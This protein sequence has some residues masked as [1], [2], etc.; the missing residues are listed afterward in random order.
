MFP[1][2]LTDIIKPKK[3]KKYQRRKSQAL[4][5]IS[6]IDKEYKEKVYK[7]WIQRRN[8]LDLGRPRL[9]SKNRKEKASMLEVQAPPM[10]IIN[11]TDEAYTDFESSRTSICLDGEHNAILFGRP[12][13][14]GAT[15]K[16]LG[17]QNVR[18]NLVPSESQKSINGLS[19]RQV[20]AFREVFDLFDGNGGGTIDADELDETLR[21]VNICLESHQ[22]AEV[23]LS[24]DHDGNGEIDFEEFMHLMTNTERFIDSLANDLM[25]DDE[26]AESKRKENEQKENMLFEALTEFMKKSAL[27]GM[28][29]I[30]DYYSSK[31]KR[32]QVPHVVNHYAAGAR[33]IGLS[34]KQ[35]KKHLMELKGSYAKHGGLNSPYARPLNTVP[36]ASSFQIVNIGNEQHYSRTHYSKEKKK[37]KEKRKQKAEKAEKSVKRR[38]TVRLFVKLPE[39]L[40]TIKHDLDLGY[41]EEDKDDSSLPMLNQRGNGWIGQRTEHIEAK[42]STSRFKNLTAVKNELTAEHLPMIR[43]NVTHA[44]TEYKRGRR[45]A[46]LQQD[47]ELWRTLLVNRI[48]PDIL[49]DH[50]RVIFSHYSGVQQRRLL[51]EMHSSMK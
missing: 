35:I 36:S 11:V 16:R 19:K 8:A 13:A 1:Q 6:K 10:P 7:E 27:K 12:D 15:I 26:K 41:R 31:Y 18:D 46:Q 2:E 42:L 24:I 3:K 23:M 30:V 32:V 37:R 43:E 20:K 51:P 48:S 34:E 9:R 40:V 29:E 39:E 45:Q 44:T 17:C 47:L 21:S 33:L 4:G 49:R 50:F 14:T 5:L 28:P 38:G 25:S 22:I